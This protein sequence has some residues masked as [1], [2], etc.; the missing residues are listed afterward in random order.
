MSSYNIFYPLGRPAALE[1]PENWK[2][3][4]RTWIHGLSQ[5]AFLILGN[6]SMKVK[7]IEKSRVEV[8]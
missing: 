8:D 5:T 4:W 3:K 6:D 7:R 2:L 1:L